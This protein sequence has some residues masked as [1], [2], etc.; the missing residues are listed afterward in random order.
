MVKTLSKT[1]RTGKH[2]CQSSRIKKSAYKKKS[3]TFLYNKGQV[4][5]KIRKLSIHNNLKNLITKE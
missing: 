3:V 5:K 4:E 2:F 1:L